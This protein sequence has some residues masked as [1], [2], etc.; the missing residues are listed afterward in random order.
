M[1]LGAPRLQGGA[2]SEE[3]PGSTALF[4]ALV[5]P[6]GPGTGNFGPPGGEQQLSPT[7]CLSPPRARRG[8]AG[9][10]RVGTRVPRTSR[11]PSEEPESPPG[12]VL[13]RAQVKK[14]GISALLLV[15]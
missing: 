5:W 12:L 15:P 7:W 10:T 4:G 11:L 8:H 2:P 1:R 13:V 3:P 6:K 9:D 14:R